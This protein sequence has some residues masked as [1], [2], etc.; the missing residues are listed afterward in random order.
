MPQFTNI[1]NDVSGASYIDYGEV[2]ACS[3]VHSNIIANSQLKLSNVEN[4]IP[5]HKLNIRKWNMPM[6]AN[7]LPGKMNIFITLSIHVKLGFII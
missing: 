4:Y 6:Y 7:I 2:V 3:I 1:N 5:H